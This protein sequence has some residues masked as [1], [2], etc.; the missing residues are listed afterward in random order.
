MEKI[1]PIILAGVRGY[2]ITI[3]DRQFS[4]L[5]EELDMCLPRFREFVETNRGKSDEQMY[6]EAIDRMILDDRLTIEKLE[7]NMKIAIRMKC[8]PSQIA[9]YQTIIE[10]KRNKT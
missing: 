5:E 6:Q 8:S 2:N 1:E 9:M 7:T 4:C 3:D 10:A